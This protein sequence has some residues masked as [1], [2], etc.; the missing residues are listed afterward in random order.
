M[1]HVLALTET[2][3]Y[4]HNCKLQVPAVSGK[5]IGT[6]QTQGLLSV[7]VVGYL[8]IMIISKYLSWLL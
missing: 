1:S 5:S 4:D 6:A 8:C 3:T 2:P 7:N